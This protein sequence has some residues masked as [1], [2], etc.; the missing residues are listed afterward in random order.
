MLI[1]TQDRKGGTLPMLK[2][3]RDFFDETFG[4]ATPRTDDPHAIAIATAALLLEVA[5]V[6]GGIDAQERDA[7]MAAL[8]AKFGVTDDEAARLSQLAQEEAAQASDYYQFTSLINERF[9]PEQKARV[10]EILWQV[11]YID[12]KLD[13]YE[14]HFIRKIAD[15]LYV[16]H[17][18]YIAT[19]LRVRDTA[20]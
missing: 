16:P 4:T 17:A 14:E 2:A 18:V 11:A 15:L 9:S 12:R 20:A 6:D 13:A 19:K 8:R 3:L 5:R 7:V 10:V 1:L